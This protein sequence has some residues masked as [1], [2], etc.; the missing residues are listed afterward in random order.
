VRTEPPVLRG[1]DFHGKPL[2]T[3][4]KDGARWVVMRPVVEAMR[5]DWPTQYRKLKAGGDR[6]RV[7]AYANTTPGS[8][9][10]FGT[11]TSLHG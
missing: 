11:A 6:W 5:L 10:C 1:L 7:L 2:S 4:E 9:A 8:T 3:F